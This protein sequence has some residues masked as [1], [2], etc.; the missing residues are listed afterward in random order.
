MSAEPGIGGFRRVEAI[1]KACDLV[2]HLHTISRLEETAEPS[3]DFLKPHGS[4][5]EGV[6]TDVKLTRSVRPESLVVRVAVEQRKPRIDGT[7]RSVAL[8]RRRVTGVGVVGREKPSTAAASV[9][10]LRQDRPSR[11]L[12]NRSEALDG[13]V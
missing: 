7:M 5:A 10:D 2:R 4:E 9:E 1:E 13:S 11:I 12:V 3:I 8:V 6:H